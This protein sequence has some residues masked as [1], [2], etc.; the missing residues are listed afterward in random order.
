MDARSTPGTQSFRSSHSKEQEKEDEDAHNTVDQTTDTKI[1]NAS[2]DNNSILN[3]STFSS[4][5]DGNNSF[6]PSQFLN[7]YTKDDS[8]TSFELDKSI[9][10]P[11]SSKRELNNTSLMGIGPSPSSQKFNFLDGSMDAAGEDEE[12][13]SNG[14]KDVLNVS[15]QLEG[16]NT[17]GTDFFKSDADAKDHSKIFSSLEAVKKH[18]STDSFNNDAK[19]TDDTFLET[20]SNFSSPPPLLD[21]RPLSPLKVRSIDECNES[22]ATS[23]DDSPT[24]RPSQRISGLVLTSSPSRD[25][26]STVAP[27][28]SLNVAQLDID[29]DCASAEKVENDDMRN[30]QKDLQKESILRDSVSI[31]DDEEMTA[32]QKKI[33]DMAKVGLG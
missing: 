3:S 23:V 28:Q 31:Y 19:D 24:R 25:S 13:I 1:A 30:L 32:L 20:L 7:S 6:D 10:S 16:G 18:M 5:N 8:Y 15:E 9:L 27:S 4:F 2:H 29:A 22:D 14:S 26:V 11:S 21:L 33:E 12:V 17:L